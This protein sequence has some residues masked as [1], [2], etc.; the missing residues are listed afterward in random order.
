MKIKIIEIPLTQGK[1]ALIDEEDFETVS[2][3]KWC[4]DKGRRT[5]YAVTRNRINGKQIKTYMHRLLLNLGKREQGDHINSNGLDNRRS[6]N[7]RCSTSSQNSMNQ[8]KQNR[9][10]S[11]K[12][13]GVYWSKN[14]KMWHVRINKNGSQINIGHFYEEDAAGQAYN[15]V[16]KELFGEFAKLNPI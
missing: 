16:A 12:Y 2:L 3:F 10:T 14:R 13:K 9:K 1:V 15:F 5:Y 8:R 4:A 11:S 6:V 7:L